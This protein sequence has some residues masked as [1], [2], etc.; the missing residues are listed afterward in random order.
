MTEFYVQSNVPPREA[1]RMHGT[2]PDSMIEM[3][4]DKYEDHAAVVLP[5]IDDADK[6]LDSI[7]HQIEDFIIYA[8]MDILRE[9]Q[10]G[11]LAARVQLERIK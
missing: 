5:A 6:I 2:L 9:V 10:E 8:D 4:L 11:L 1:F 3:L 7:W